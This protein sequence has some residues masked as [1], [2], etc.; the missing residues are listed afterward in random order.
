MEPADGKEGVT[1]RPIDLRRGKSVWGF[2]ERK[3]EGGGGMGF[4]A[5]EFSG[6]ILMGRGGGQRESGVYSRGF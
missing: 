3:R 2:T 6:S 4:D 5:F 1:T